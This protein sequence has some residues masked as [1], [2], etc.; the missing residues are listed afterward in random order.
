MPQPI[1]LPL[2]YIA[3]RAQDLTKSGMI[4]Y[5]VKGG[6]AAQ[7]SGATA[8]PGPVAGV[9]RTHGR[10]GFVGEPT[11]Q[12]HAEPQVGAARK[13]FRLV[14]PIPQADT[15]PRR[16]KREEEHLSCSA[17]ARDR[18]RLFGR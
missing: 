1:G 7:S 13:I 14:D 16:P 15:A 3:L 10:G 11:F 8:T 18:H 4:G 5:C 6:Y 12:R 9:A 2:R 17:S